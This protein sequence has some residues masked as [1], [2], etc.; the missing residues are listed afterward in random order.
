[1]TR[2]SINLCTFVYIAVH[3]ISAIQ[4]SSKLLPLLQRF[5]SALDRGTFRHG[6]SQDEPIALVIAPHQV[7]NRI[8]ASGEPK[9]LLNSVLH[10]PHQG[11]FDEIPMG[12][13]N[14]YLDELQ[15]PMDNT[16]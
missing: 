11:V 8:P 14:G 6:L 10:E 2:F 1:M 4:I 13:T 9:N 7:V 5:Y 3:L 16:T 15:I 12:S